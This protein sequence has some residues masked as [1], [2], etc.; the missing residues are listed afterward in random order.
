[1]YR[2]LELNPQLAGFAGDIDLRMSLYRDT[3]KRI[4][5]EGQSLNDFANAHN[6]Y[7]FH[8][9]EGGWYYREWAPSAYQLYLMGDFN[10]W[11][12]TSHPL[13]KLGNGDW[14]LFLP[15]ED[16][17]WDGCKV[18]TVVD[19][20]LTRTEH[21]PLFARRVVQ[22]P[23]TVTWCAEV[24]D[25]RRAFP[26]TDEAFRGED[27]LY[28]YE[29]HVG[30]AQE[31]GRVG[32]YR[33][34]AD[35]TLPH[36]KQ[37]GYNTI[38]LM[39]IMEH[40]YYGS[41]GY[42][43]SNFYAASSWFGKPEDLKYLVNKA[44]E[45]GIRVLL[46][47]VH[48]H[49]VKNTAEGINL[50]DGTV[51]QFFHDGPKGD[52]PAWG[53][54]CF[55]YGSN[56]VMHFLLSN[57]KFWMTEYHFD[58]FRFDGVTSMLYHDHGLGTDFDSNSK[59]FSMNTHVEAI[60]YL[61]LANELIRQVNPKAITIAEDMSG[62]P[63]MCLPIEDGGIGFDYRLGMGLP[64]MWVRTVKTLRDEDWDIG[65]MW[66]EM[67][68]R[69]PGEGTVAY[70]ESH[71]QAL[72][73]DK[74]MIFRLADAAMYTD[75]DKAIHN[76]VIDRA[77]ALHK[78]IR[79]FTLSGGGEAYLNFMGNEFGHPEWIDFPREGNG[80]SFHYC[81]R[82]WS[83]KNNGYLKYQW[84][85]DF[86]EDMVKL[87]KA[88]R[89]FDQRMGDQR[90][91]RPQD[92]VLVFYRNGLLF[93]YNFHP[94]QS[95]TDVVIPVPNRA[96]YTVAMCS[97]DERYGGQQLVEHMTYRVRTID[98]KPCIVL[99]L[100]ARTAVVLQEGKIHQPR[101]KKEKPAAEAMAEKPAAEAMAEKPAKKAPGRKRKAA[102]APAEE[103]VKRKPGR[104]RKVKAE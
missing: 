104:P 24:V 26:W 103:A 49:A 61:Q 99:Y 73:G 3:K 79:L 59:Y 43:V 17:L 6:Y 27:L 34:F 36:V 90:L 14:E 83:L 74:T 48:S 28:I 4:L 51:W 60:T 55:N 13:K 80:W 101:T 8:P 72:V 2:I 56:G 44:H 40:P 70:V 76:P 38:Q 39:A 21:L 29:A 7:G 53:T 100:P 11:N 58:G 62:M 12:Q 102:E 95:V 88:H 81:R 63:G 77:I 30:M 96:N 31:E 67:C 23:K 25:E 37:A 65:K 15:G 42:Q 92:K 86:D 91:Y 52:H 41:F 45:M 98:G 85:N 20:N 18:K 19:Y 54:K 16:A 87:T 82:Q 9:A 71:D 50:F 22:D 35:N 89:I 33:E 57:L 32:T 1:M 94:T 66:G 78:M 69:R 47:V 64:D 93:A 97:D 84:L 5:G 10:G 75:M 68:L 46:D